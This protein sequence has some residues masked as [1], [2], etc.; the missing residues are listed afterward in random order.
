MANIISYS[1]PTKRKKGPTILFLAAPPANHL[2][3]LSLFPVRTP[4]GGSKKS[5]IVPNKHEMRGPTISRVRPK[6]K[7]FT[8]GQQS[9]QLAAKHDLSDSLLVFFIHL[10]FCYHLPI[11]PHPAPCAAKVN[12]ATSGKGRR[13]KGWSAPDHI[14]SWPLEHSHTAN[15]PRTA[16]RACACARVRA[17]V[18]G[19]GGDGLDPFFLFFLFFF[20][21]FRVR[22]VCSSAIPSMSLGR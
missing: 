17:C 3:P 21:P 6:A 18:C 1:I 8:V 10:L 22:V 9:R 19:G 14:C 7:L 20:F 11:T 15:S 16:E 5:F 2:F 4:A 13:G 12:A